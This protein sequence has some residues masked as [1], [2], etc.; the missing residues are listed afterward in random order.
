VV[1]RRA[2]D[3]IPEVRSPV[4]SAR[5]PGLAPWEFPRHCPVCGEPLQRLEGEAD[6]FCVNVDCPGQRVQRI[7]HFAARGAMDIEGLGERTVALLVREGLLH[8]VADIYTLDAERLS[9]FEGFGEVSVGNLQRAIAASRERPLANLL[10]GLSI[11][12]LGVTGS[13][14]LARS[15][16]HLDRI[17][18]APVEEMA[19]VEGVGS[20]IARSVHDFFA[21]ERNRAVIER[22]RA[23]GCN[24]V[25]PGAPDIPPVLSGRSIVVTGTLEGWSR[26]AAE[27]AITAR[28]GKAPASVSKKT[29]A[30]VA[31]ADPGM[32]KIAKAEALGIPIVDEAAFRVLLETGELPGG[33]APGGDGASTDA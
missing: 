7:S 6:T 25:G 15:L 33:G 26:E 23:A 19:E 28:S 2:G 31:G 14:V 3:V 5:P 30:V 10:V 27:A 18:D 21:L 29:T 20:V 13:Q 1:V 16:G 32:A 22:L 12:H 8:D 4:L 17:L 11:R 9:G 24:F